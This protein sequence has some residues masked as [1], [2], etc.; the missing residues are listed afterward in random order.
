MI[1]FR[2]IEPGDQQ[3]ITAC[4]DPKQHPFT[5][6]SFVSLFSWRKTYGLAIAGDQDFFVI[7]SW[8]DNAFYCPCGDGEKCRRFIQD[9]LAEEE[10]ARFLY[11]T[12]EQSME[13]RQQGFQIQMRDDLSEYIAA[14]DSLA[15]REGYHASNSY[16]M[17]VRHFKK[18]VS[19]SVR[20]VTARDLPLLLEINKISAGNGVVHDE[21]VIQT[22]VAHF[23]AL[24]MEGCLLETDAGQRAF[25]LGYPDSQETFTMTMT[26]HDCSLP[27]QVTAVLANAFA[28]QLSGKY[29]LINLEEDLGLPGLRRAKLLYS[30][31]DRLNV[32]EAIK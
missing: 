22:E 1:S 15:L 11:L 2:D 12:K 8:H 16:K 26:K 30:P 17:K 19:F 14:V 32:Y 3:W 20:P 27:A 13:M 31:V 6:L 23:A 5:A 29:R 28:C 4:R 18:S 24:G 9:T 10:A 25:I 21:E 7:R